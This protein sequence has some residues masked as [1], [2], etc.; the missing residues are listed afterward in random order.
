MKVAE[1]LDYGG[2]ENFRIGERSMPIPKDEEVLVKVAYA[3]LRWGDIMGRRGIPVR[4]ATPPFVPGQ[5]AVGT[6]ADLGAG[7]TSLKVG[8]R[9][10][11]Q[12]QGGGYAEYLAIAANRA[13]LVPDGVPLETALV[14]RVNMPTAYMAVY[15]W[16]KVHEGEIVLLHAAAGGVGMLVV[17]IL[18]RRFKNATVIG[19]AGSDTKV[20]AVR[21]NGADHAINYK[22]TDYVKAV[23]EIAGVK[24]RG[25]APGAPPAGVHVALNGVGG[26][27][28]KKDR[29]VIRRLGRWVL[30]GTPGGV[31][32]IN[33]YENSYD[34]IA[35]MPFSI[36]PFI[37]TDAYARSQAFT[38]EW[39]RSEPLTAPSIHPIEDIAAVQNAMERGETMG[40]IVFKL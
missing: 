8:D 33:P 24:P 29:R 12:P 17:Q 2:P 26:E 14:Y 28:L 34:S 25:F 18:K 20:A 16:A 39:L 1:L 19:L 3:G 21:A 6:V 13:G 40:K 38:E 15:E 5:E 36:I 30:F 37:G 23:E 35:I 27:T 4:G 31:E 11:C 9:V 32:P 7:V 22:T 10:V